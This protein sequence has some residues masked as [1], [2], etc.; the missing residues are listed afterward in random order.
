MVIG[1]VG[2]ARRPHRAFQHLP[3]RGLPL[4][5]AAA[6]GPFAV[7]RE[8]RR[9][10]RIIAGI[11]EGGIIDQDALDRELILDPLHPHWDAGGPRLRHRRDGCHRHGDRQ[12][13]T[14]SHLPLSSLPT[15]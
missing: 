11:E 6:I 10:A 12:K 7:G 5:A 14:L 3:D 13:P 2:R 8:Q 15:S 1:S 4:V 9:V